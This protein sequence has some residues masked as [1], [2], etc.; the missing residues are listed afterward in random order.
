M[1]ATSREDT[2]FLYYEDIP[3]PDQYKIIVDWGSITGESIEKLI[4]KT[5]KNGYK[6]ILVCIYLNQLS[7]WRLSPVAHY[8]KKSAYQF[9][10]MI[11]FKER[12]IYMDYQASTP[13]DPRVIEAMK[14]FFYDK[15]GNPHASDHSFGWEANAAIEE[16][17]QKIASAIAAD[18]DEIIFTSGATEA[19]NLAIIGAAGYAP[20]GRRR[21]LVSSIEHK[22]VLEAACIASEQYNLT[23]EQLPVD[24]NGFIRLDILEDRL[25]PDVLLV[26]VMTINNE[27]GTIQ[28]LKDVAALCRAVGALIH[29]DAVQAPPAMSLNVNE[30]DVDFLSL[31]SHKLYGPK[32]IGALFIRRDVQRH[33]K[34]LIY[35]GGQQN[36]LRAGTLP[37]PLCVGFGEAIALITSSDAVVE[38]MQIRSLRDQFIEC[39][40]LIAP[41]AY[42]NG[43]EGDSRHPGNAN[44]CFTGFD[45]HE[46]IGAL[47]PRVAASTGAACT[48]GIPEP[49]YV[50]RAIGLL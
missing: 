43:A 46:L 44:I 27:I 19:N 5:H 38:R 42:I 47:Q 14:P 32:G 9:S 16:A 33:I 31:S 35:G 25:A 10:K 50:L 22:C 6:N 1:Q 20:A 37:V 41:N 13:V 21:I 7:S 30:L 12:R 26:S 11:N 45:A 36:G 28:P 3:G 29:T 34:P 39:I 23:I 2:S 15:P 17:S 48:S 4:H 40:T 8:G 49:S 24:R 18:S